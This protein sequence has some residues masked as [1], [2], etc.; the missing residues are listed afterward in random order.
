MTEN[1]IADIVVPSA[2]SVH[3]S[4][5]PGLLESVYEVIL[6]KELRKRGLEVARQVIIPLE[7]EG[8][9]IDMAFRA[10]IIVE[11][12]VILELK[13]VEKNA[14]VHKRQLLTY[15]KLTGLKLGFV[16]NFGMD[17][18]IDGIERVANNL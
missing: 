18:M 17:R 12:K 4:F 6:A 2:V 9:R 14:A 10:D 11:N 13:A 8:E 16:L 5:G 1:E 7:Y 3:K 15:L